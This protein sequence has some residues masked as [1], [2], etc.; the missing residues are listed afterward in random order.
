MWRLLRP[1]TLSCRRIDNFRDYHN[2]HDYQ[3]HDFRGSDFYFARGLSRLLQ[4]LKF[5]LQ[6]SSRLSRLLTEILQKS[7]ST[8]RGQ[9]LHEKNRVKMNITVKIWKIPGSAARAA[10]SMSPYGSLWRRCCPFPAFSWLPRVFI[11]F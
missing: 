6:K 8:K 4:L 5:F 7:N 1:S 10:V 3:A 9:I 11:R 2:F